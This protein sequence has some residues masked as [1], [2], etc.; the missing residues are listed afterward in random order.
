MEGIRLFVC[1]ELFLKKDTHFAM[2]RFYLLATALLSVMLP[3]SSLNIC[4]VDVPERYGYLLDAISVGSGM[5]RD[6][7]PA[8][9]RMFEI[10]TI[11]YTAGVA[12]FLTGFLIRIAR[13]LLIIRSEGFAEHNG[14]KLVFLPEGSGSPFSFFRYVFITREHYHSPEA[15][16]ML[17]HEQ[18]HI[19]QRH[20]VDLLL[21]EMLTIVQW[22][23]PFI[24]MYR[25]SV[26]HIHEY[27]A[28]DGVIRQSY[29]KEAY[30]FV[31]LHIGTGLIAN[32]ITNNFNHSLL[33]RR[34]IMMNRSKSLP[35]TRWKII[36]IIPVMAVLLLVFSDVSGG[37]LD[38]AL[39]WGQPGRA[40]A[41]LLPAEA[42]SEG[43]EGLQPAAYTPQG[44]DD[45]VFV[46]VD[47]APSFI[48]GQEALVKYISGN[49]H[50]PDEAKKQ[51][52]QGTVFVSF[53]INEKGKVTNGKVLRGIGSGCDEEALRVIMSMPDWD[54]GKN[55]EKPV[56]VNITLP[57]KF[58]LSDKDHEKDV[59]TDVKTDTRKDNIPE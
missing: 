21:L 46:K 11:C 32:T 39:S 57:I 8:N 19:R 24:W 27:I 14:M 40:M 56:K 34:F 58:A 49:I 6:V 52:I 22:V 5:V 30:Q 35:H 26:K 20:S 45:S 25:K 51:G 16:E 7:L 17:M 50:Y 47:V 36:A 10:I 18:V 23:N 41:G 15:Q 29:D 54:P 43:T 55:G 31:L 33:K 59:G 3:F 44:Q 13:L 1:I 28:D 2:N 53:Q 38:Q 48:G 4:L 42:S 12:V 9:P 37:Y